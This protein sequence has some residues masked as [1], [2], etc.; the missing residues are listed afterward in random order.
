WSSDVCSSDLSKQNSEPLDFPERRSSCFY[1]LL[2]QAEPARDES[3]A[4]LFLGWGRP[5]NEYRSKIQCH[6]NGAGPTRHART[7]PAPGGGSPAKRFIR[8][9][10]FAQLD[11]SVRA[12]RF[13]CFELPRCCT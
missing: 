10:T 6:R 13:G 12:R 2:V 5:G 3:G 7:P 8:I 11:C 1:R 9:R 4:L